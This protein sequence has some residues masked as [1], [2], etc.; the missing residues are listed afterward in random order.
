MTLLVIFMITCNQSDLHVLWIAIDS[1][2][3]LWDYV[4]DTICS[5]CGAK[6]HTARECFG[7]KGQ[8][9]ALLEETSCATCRALLSSAPTA[10]FPPRAKIEPLKA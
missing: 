7:A 1:A 8:H 9:Y 3:G 10:G 2:V 6:G 4:Q 5:R